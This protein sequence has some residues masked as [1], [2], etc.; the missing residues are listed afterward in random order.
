MGVNPVLNVT[1]AYSPVPAQVDQV[2]LRLPAGSTLVQALQAS[3]LPERHGLGPLESLKAGVW[4]KLRPLDT[5]LRDQDRVEIYR[6]LKVDPKE[7]RRQRYRRSKAT[8]AEGERP[9]A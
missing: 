8:V 6:P 3:G 7:A 5:P 4:M 2:A 1:V 9:A